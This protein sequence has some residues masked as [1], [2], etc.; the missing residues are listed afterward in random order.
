MDR[1]IASFEAVG[2][3]YLDIT[4]KVHVERIS[5]LN[6]KL[7]HRLLQYWGILSYVE[8]LLGLRALW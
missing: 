4:K 3:M 1:A 7:K 2:D 6:L 8:I 5:G